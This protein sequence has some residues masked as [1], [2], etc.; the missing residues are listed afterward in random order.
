MPRE[1]G[2]VARAHVRVT[3]GKPSAERRCS[4]LNRLVQ[5]QRFATVQA[6]G[7][8][9]FMSDIEQIRQ[10]CRLS[11][12]TLTPLEQTRHGEAFAQ[13]FDM[14][15]LLLRSNRIAAYLSASGELD[16]SALFPLIHRSRKRLFLPVLRPHPQR[17]LWFLHYPEKGPLIE[18]RFGI[19]EPPLKHQHICLPWAL[20][21]IV[22]PLVAFDGRCNRLGMGGG[23]YDRTLAYLR[24]RKR[25]RKPLLVGAAHECQRVDKIATNEWDIPLDLV[26]TES[27]IYRRR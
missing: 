20:D 25:W 13:L 21:L 22:V 1:Q 18:N 8:P 2:T 7:V 26:I 6:G 16:P 14:A 27:R 10:R 9:F 23:F 24:H 19:A 5:E 3:S 17:K 4:H 12:R 15:G 11:R